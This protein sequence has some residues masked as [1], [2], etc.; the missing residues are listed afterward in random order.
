MIFREKRR[1]RKSMIYDL[2]RKMINND[3][4][5]DEQ[6]C[7]WNMDGMW[8]WMWLWMGGGGNVVCAIGNVS[9]LRAI[10]AC[11]NQRTISPHD[12]TFI[13][14]THF[15]KDLSNSFFHRMC[16]TYEVDLNK[17]CCSWF[18]VVLVARKCRTRT[19]VPSLMINLCLFHQSN[20]D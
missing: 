8:M 13:L 6:L 5:K 12:R 7:G 11:S 18:C 17:I 14:H 10:A 2:Q 15:H 3:L 20:T 1:G 4:F 19:A 9:P 16:V